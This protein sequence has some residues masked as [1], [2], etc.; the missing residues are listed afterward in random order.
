M[1]TIVAWACVLSFVA[2]P[3]QQQDVPQFRSGVDVAQFTV[4]VL[5]K[6]RHPVTGLTASD[7]EVLVD[8]SPRPLAAFAAVTLSDNRSLPP[9]RT[10]SS[11]SRATRLRVVARIAV[12][13]PS[14]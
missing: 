8:G 13:S 10:T 7:F 3:A 9:T 5:D 1:R 6:N 12:T 11:P 4:T 2:V 14:R